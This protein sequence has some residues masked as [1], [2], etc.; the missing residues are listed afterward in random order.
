VVGARP[1]RVLFID[2]D[3]NLAEIVSAL[4]AA[5]GY[6]FEGA[7]GPS[8]LARFDSGAWARARRPRHT[9]GEPWPNQW[10]DWGWA[11]RVELAY[12]HPRTGALTTIEELVRVTDPDGWTLRLGEADVSCWVVL[13]SGRLRHPVFVSD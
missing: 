9:R 10:G 6:A 11:A 12:T 8:G 5:F 4:L 7:D 13:P 1:P 3:P 2:D